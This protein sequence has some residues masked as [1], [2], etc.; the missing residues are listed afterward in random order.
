MPT[1]LRGGVP[2]WHRSPE[3]TPIMSTPLLTPGL[4]ARLPELYSQ[5]EVTDPVVQVLLLGANAWIWALTEYSDTAPDGCE[6]LAFGWV[7]GDFPELGYVPMDE[8][9]DL[10]A[11]CLPGHG[12]VWVDEAFTPRPLSQVRAEAEGIR[13]RLVDSLR[14]GERVVVRL[15]GIEA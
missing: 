3:V 15:H 4:K 5:E 11:S 6:H 13:E 2:R 1:S 8:L 10:N 9:D 7:C 14:S 12:F